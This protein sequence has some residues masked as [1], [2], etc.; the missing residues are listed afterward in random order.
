VII[1]DSTMLHTKAVSGKY[2]QLCVCLLACNGFFSFGLQNR[3]HHLM[4]SALVPIALLVLNKKRCTN[5]VSYI[6]QAYGGAISATV[7]S[8]AF[9]IITFGL[10]KA[11]SLDTRCINC[12]MR[13]TNVFI[14]ESSALSTVGGQDFASSQGVFVRATMI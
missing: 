4:A 11:I 3:A 9:S 7:G 10:S 2:R 13:V 14:S 5:L 12:H 8:Y 6:L 1:V